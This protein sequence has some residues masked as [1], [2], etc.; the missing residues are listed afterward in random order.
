MR[1]IVLFILIAVF[2][3]FNANA[4]NKLHIVQPG[5]TL[6]ALSKAH[7]KDPYLWGKIWMNNTYLNDP[8][9][10]FPG[11]VIE[12]TKY[13][14]TIYKKPK[15]EKAKNRMKPSVSLSKYDNFIFFDGY[16]YYSDCGEGFCLWHKKDLSLG[17]IRYD[18]YNMLEAKPGDAVFIYAKKKINV[19]KLYVYRKI[20]DHSNVNICPGGSVSVLVPIG[21]LKVLSEVKPLVYKCIIDKAYA[22]ISLKDMVNSVYPYKT[23]KKNAKFVKLG[24]IPVNL[25]AIYDF[26]LT[27]HV[28]YYMFFNVKNG[29]WSVKKRKNSKGYHIVKSE[30]NISRS[31]VGKRVY[32]ER[33]NPNLPVNTVIGRGIV[34]S[35]YKN[36]LSVFFDTYNGNLKEIPDKTQNYILR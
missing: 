18:R 32:L 3:Y 17:K 11:E 2:T 12:Y 27:P 31:I 35:Q 6:W 9:L 29:F 16:K 14:I 30:R 8:N 25:I 23:L 34:V 20:E 19:K 21:E 26:S 10:I 15:T 28:G 1:R 36:Y 4:S 22:E 13:G 33:V 24:N 5:D 7:Y